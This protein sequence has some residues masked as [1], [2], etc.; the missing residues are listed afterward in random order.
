[1]NET[2]STKWHY[3]E[4]KAKGYVL[5]IRLS[6]DELS[7]IERAANGAGVSQWARGVLLKAI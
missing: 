5:K 1:M 7:A 3:A 2:S 6:Q 4:G